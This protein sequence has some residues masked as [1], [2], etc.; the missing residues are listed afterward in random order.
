[1]KILL[2]DDHSAIRH[3]L[4]Q[5]LLEAYPASQIEEVADGGGLIRL[6]L[7]GGWDLVIADISMPVVN[8]L[9]A[10]TSRKQK[11]QAF[12]EFYLG[13]AQDRSWPIL[14]LEFK[15]FALRHPGSKERLRKAFEMAKPT[16]KPASAR[17]FERVWTTSKLSWRATSGTALSPPKS[18]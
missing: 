1:M 18:T 15:L 14:T 10:C 7:T 5:L 3:R 11:M 8:G 17:D 6:A 4:K 9:E 12:R 16:R 2:A 13:L